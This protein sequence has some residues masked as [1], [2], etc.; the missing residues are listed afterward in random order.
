MRT[1]S[2]KKCYS[3]YDIDRPTLYGIYSSF[4]Y[5]LPEKSCPAA[6]HTHM[7][8]ASQARSSK[9]NH[10]N[11]HKPCLNSVPNSITS[12]NKATLKSSCQ[13]RCVD[14]I[15]LC[16]GA[17]SPFYALFLLWISAFRSLFSSRQKGE[18]SSNVIVT[19]DLDWPCFRIISIFLS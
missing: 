1:C 5:A 17:F 15:A 11:V 4:L 7:H 8:T 19:S 12:R 16:F 2:T 3:N 13:S 18:R 9:S 6:P 10:T 14:Q